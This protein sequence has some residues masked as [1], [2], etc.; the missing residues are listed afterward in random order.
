MDPEGQR[1]EGPEKTSGAFRY[2]TKCHSIS[3]GCDNRWFRLDINPVVTIASAVIIWAL[4]AWCMIEPEEVCAIIKYFYLSSGSRF[5]PSQEIWYLHCRL[6][7]QLIKSLPFFWQ[8]GDMLYSRYV[9]LSNIFVSKHFCS[10][11]FHW[12]S[13][14]SPNWTFRRNFQGSF[15]LCDFWV[16]F[17][18]AH[19]G[20]YM[21]WYCC[22]SHTV[23]TLPLSPVPAIYCDKR[24]R[25]RYQKKTHSINEPSLTLDLDL[26]G[27]DSLSSPF[28]FRCCCGHKNNFRS[29]QLITTTFI[30]HVYF[31]CSALY[32]LLFLYILHIAWVGF[33]AI[34]HQI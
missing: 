20:L 12:Y 17:L 31:P 33:K 7:R 29:K 5:S 2:D 21:S 11:T 26:D 15:T 10:F 30:V 8:L 4:V 6:W 9:T 1:T 3:L 32:I 25:S 19:N 14:H 28:L 13:P 23:W 16:R 34:L 18:F 27:D 24:N 22:R